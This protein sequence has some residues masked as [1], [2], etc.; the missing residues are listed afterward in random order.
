M[1]RKNTRYYQAKEDQDPNQI[2]NQNNKSDNFQIPLQNIK[3]IN[4]LSPPRKHNN[5]KDNSKIKED[6]KHKKMNQNI[7]QSQESKME[8]E[9]MIKG[10]LIGSLSTQASNNIY[11]SLDS[12]LKNLNCANSNNINT[13]SK[14]IFFF[15]DQK[16][17]IQKD[18]PQSLIPVPSTNPKP[19]TKNKKET[20]APKE[21]EIFKFNFLSSEEYISFSGEYINDIYSNLLLDEK[22]LK[23]LYGY[24][25]NQHDINEQMRAILIDWLIEVHYKFHLK[26]ETLYQTV[27]IIDSYLSMF[28]ILRAKLQLL[29]IAALLISC[30]SQEIYYPQLFELIDITDGAY[31]KEEL[32]DM[33]NH[34]LKI[35]GFNI[36]SPTAI[37]FYNI[38]SKAFNFDQKQYLLG[39]YFMESSLIDYQMIKYSASVIGVSCA[40]V[41]MKFCGINNYK[42]LYSKNVI[43]EECPQKIIK[44]A[45]R[46][47]CHLVKNLS[48]SSLKAV[49]DKYSL[50][51]FLNVAQFCEQN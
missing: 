44:E 15:Q 51:Q 31:V 16:N 4:N 25:Q 10:N 43:K 42:C 11:S 35:L 7:S 26:D 29:G 40:Y 37:E 1:E 39:K 18:N 21:K 34:I 27:F 8:I 19:P 38:I 22:N 30:K 41:V 47:I 50:P 2:T 33:E 3:N 46:E 32:V 20:H 45:A 48:N 14:N 6:L 36:V 13:G 23:P 17:N 28:P 5:P 49:R 24:I 12:N 9:E